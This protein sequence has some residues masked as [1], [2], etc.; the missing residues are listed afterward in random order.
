MAAIRV[1]KPGFLSSVQ[2]RGRCGY[3]HLGISASGAADP[4][5]LR[6]GNL[7]L[8]N[9]A[10]AAAIEM[11]LVGGSFVYEG[12]AL[13]ALTGADFGA[14]LSGRAMPR[15]EPVRVQSG[16]HLTIGATRSGARCYLCVR[17]GIDVPEVL[18]SRSTHLLSGLGGLDGRQLAAGDVL[19]IGAAE[20]APGARPRTLAP[21]I[22]DGLYGSKTIRFTPGPQA[23]SFAPGT[24]EL[25]AASTYTVSEDSNRMGIRFTGPALE[26]G[27][28]GEMLTEGVSLGA[29]QVPENGLPIVLWVEHQTTG[30]YPK[31][32]NVCSADMHLVGQLR[33]R[34]AVRFQPIPM[35]AARHLLVEREALLQRL[36]TGR[37]S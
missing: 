37:T 12:A 19:A 20:A 15:W 10:S 1:E 35:T 3:A 11:T 8:G 21:S 34:D 4:L 14:L 23:D 22:I 27:K 31:V 5:A 17:G 28:A 2:D 30:G 9:D 36:A 16:D 25:L 33:P 32:G 29:I 18:G 24:M 7:L 26:R 13:V 6:L